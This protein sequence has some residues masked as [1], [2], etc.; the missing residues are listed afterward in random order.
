MTRS[1][2]AVIGLGGQSAFFRV[3]HFPMPG[4]TVSC[5]HLFYELGGKGYNQAVACA[6]MGVPT[7]FIGA[8]GTDP[9]AT[10]CRKALEA[11]GI[12]ICMI[13]KNSPTA[14]AATVA[15]G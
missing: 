7:S 5:T 6:R 12:S 15:A 1:G 2:V 11:E 14:F 4:E 13:P 8:V 10:D 9:W 3:P